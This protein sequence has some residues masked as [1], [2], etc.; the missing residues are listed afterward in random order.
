MKRNPVY[1]N[2]ELNQ[3]PFKLHSRD[4]TS[5]EGAIWDKHH[6]H[7]GMEFVYVQ[8]GEGIVIIEQKIIPI[9]PGTVFYF[10]PY[11]MHRMKVYAS[12]ACTY[13]RSKILFEPEIFYPLFEHLPVMKKFFMM[14][15]KERLPTQ[16]IDLS[17][18]R[19]ELEHLFELYKPNKSLSAEEQQERFSILL[20]C[21]LQLLQH[22]WR[23]SKKTSLE[24]PRT[25]NHSEKALEWIETHFRESF[26]LRKMADELFLNPQYLSRLFRNATGSTISEYVLTRRLREACLFICTTEL[27]IQEIAMHIGIPNVSR[28]C[29]VFKHRI[30]L[31]PLQYRV[32]NNKSKYS[33]V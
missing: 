8:H 12:E 31:T 27:S 29:Q 19:E 26:D 9:K 20:L 10:Q 24:A 13:T 18:R 25:L 14:L 1:Q 17:D 6:A 11:Q 2:F 30:G 23:L 33:F 32:S 5:G 15:W 21:F 16:V 7:Q 4:V 22:S 28:F 3:T